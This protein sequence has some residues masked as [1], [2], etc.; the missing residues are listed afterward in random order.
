[1]IKRSEIIMGLAA[2]SDTN[3]LL[4]EFKRQAGKK[5]Y[6]FYLLV[7][8]YKPRLFH[9]GTKIEEHQPIDTWI[10]HQL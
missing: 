7:L 8:V 3:F 2:L 6:S 10:E 1:M 9:T 4:S 5:D